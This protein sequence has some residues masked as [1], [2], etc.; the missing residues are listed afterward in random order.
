MKEKEKRKIRVQISC[1]NYERCVLCYC[2]SVWV[3]F[4]ERFM[5]PVFACVSENLRTVYGDGVC[6]FGCKRINGLLPRCLPVCLYVFE[7]FCYV[8]G[9]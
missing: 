4:Y 8:G 1:L 9:G 7:R 5:E 6:V 3:L 2:L